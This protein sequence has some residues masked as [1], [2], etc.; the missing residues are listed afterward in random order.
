[1]NKE[2]IKELSGNPELIPGIYNYCD[3]WCER[4][5]FTARCMN[6]A[7]REEQFPESGSRDIRNDRFRQKL[8]GTFRTIHELLEGFLTEDTVDLDTTSPLDLAEEHERTQPEPPE[9]HVCSRAAEQYRKMLDEWFDARGNQLMDESH[10]ASKH[11]EGIAGLKDSLE[12]LHWYQEQIYAK[13]IRAVSGQI[14]ERSRNHSDENPKDS[15][16]SAKVALLGIE[17]SIPAWM[18]LREHWPEYKDESI[19][20]LVHLDRLRKNIEHHFPGARDFIRPGF[21]EKS[22]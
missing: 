10:R 12:I 19:D 16:G 11:T 20:F 17:R 6:F 21:D 7:F 8:S 22:P 13:I 2:H 3:R 9:N 18:A 1:M 14:D 15:D 5:A 4:C